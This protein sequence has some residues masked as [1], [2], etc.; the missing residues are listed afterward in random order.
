MKTKVKPIKN[1]ALIKK[2]KK[3]KTIGKKAKKTDKPTKD[4]VLVPPIT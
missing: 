2:Q 4:T 1:L 3:K